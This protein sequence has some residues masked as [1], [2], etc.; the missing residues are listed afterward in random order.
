[1]NL[2]KSQKTVRGFL[3]PLMGKLL[4]F[5]KDPIRSFMKPPIG[6]SLAQTLNFVLVPNLHFL[7]RLIAC[8]RGI[9][10]N[11]NHTQKENWT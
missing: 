7:Q 2:I 4:Y 8:P 9:L 3:K 5:C 10:G 11:N 1:M 6:K